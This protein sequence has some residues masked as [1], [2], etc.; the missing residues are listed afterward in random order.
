MFG[1]SFYKGN[2]ACINMENYWKSGP[3]IVLPFKEMM[4]P[5]LVSTLPVFCPTYRGKNQ[6]VQSCVPVDMT[7]GSLQSGHS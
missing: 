2:I 4:A 5:V 1:V 6:I 3:K 7:N